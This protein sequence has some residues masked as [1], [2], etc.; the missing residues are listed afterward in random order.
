V[1]LEFVTIDVLKWTFLAKR[2][3][4]IIEL[5]HALSVAIDPSKMQPGQ[6]PLAYDETLDWDDFPSEKSLADWCLGLVIIDEETSTVRLVHKSLHD[7]LTL[8]HEEGEIFSHGHSKI[9][10]TC[11]QYMCFNDD[12]REIDPLETKVTKISKMYVGRGSVFSIML[13]ITS[14]ATCV[15]KAHARLT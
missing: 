9:A 4:T 10:Y 13:S 5:R 1:N 15:I 11:L 14:D 6:L 2:P 12:E 3:L 7:Y 8:L